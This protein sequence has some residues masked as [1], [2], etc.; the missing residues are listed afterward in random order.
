MHFLFYALVL[1]YPFAYT[2]YR[3]LLLGNIELGFDDLMLVVLILFLA[4]KFAYRSMKYSYKIILL[5]PKQ[6]VFALAAGVIF[7]LNILIISLFDDRSIGGWVQCTG[8]ISA[9]LVTVLMIRSY[10]TFTTTVTLFKFA[11][12]VLAVSAILSAYGLLNY[13]VL[14]T[15]PSLYRAYFGA[16]YSSTGLIQSRGGFGINLA[17]V[18]PFA[19]QFIMIGGI[20][21]AEKKTKNGFLWRSVHFV[22]HW[23]LFVV[24]I[25]ATITSG[26]RSTWLMA[27]VAIST[28]MIF[29]FS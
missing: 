19:L 26:S 4:F 11:T 14:N 27:L 5:T 25:W 12:F 10:K 17:F 2:N 28:F 1:F 7:S 8:F 24:L 6:S 13:E 22:S 21:D 29:H 9:L 23:L 20:D 3:K 16:K 18:L 15:K